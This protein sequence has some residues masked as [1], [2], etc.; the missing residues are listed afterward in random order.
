MRAF[1]GGVFNQPNPPAAST[2]GELREGEHEAGE[3]PAVAVRE[4][5]DRRTAQQDA[6]AE[7]VQRMRS[8]ARNAA[9]QP[10]PCLRRL[11]A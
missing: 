1:H 2:T 10:M 11:T 6:E 3:R 4:H 9:R 8:H 5:A 7:A